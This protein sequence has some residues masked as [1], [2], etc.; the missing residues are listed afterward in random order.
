M[1]DQSAEFYDDI[2]S[3]VKNYKKETKQLISWIKKYVPHCKNI[4][5][6]A[7][8]TGE[9]AKFLKEKYS[10]DGIDLNPSFLEI[11]KKKNPKGHYELADMTHFDLKKKYDLIL[12]L[13]SSIGYVK[14]L[15][16][17]QKTLACF[18]HHLT[19]GGMAFV[20]P[21]LTSQNVKDGRLQLYEVETASSK[22]CRMSLIE[23]K[24]R[25]SMIN[26]HYLIGK[27]KQIQH[28]T[29]Q[30]HLGLFTDDEMRSAFQQ[31]GFQVQ[32]KKTKF[33]NRGIYLARLL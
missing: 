33:L 2:Y 25:I 1:Y 18:A 7:C 3:P 23:V 4:L 6:V 21:W 16:N 31:A 29:E 14:T 19:Q 9:H 28:R 8:G 10:V 26:F 5:D 22:I 32:Y 13:F 11:S 17:L 15:P 20:E 27:D 30:H 24:D 12:C